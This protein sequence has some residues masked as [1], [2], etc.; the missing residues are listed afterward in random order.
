MKTLHLYLTRQVLLALL[1]TVVVFT[2][3]LLLANVLREVL[4]LLVNQQITLALA[5]RAI[6]LLIPFVLVFALPMGMLTAAL[7]VFG[8]FSADQELTA[9]R[10]GGVSLLSL[11]TPV[12]LLSAALSLVCGWINLQIAPLCRVAYKQLLFEIGTTPGGLLLP[13]KTFIKDFPGRIVYVGRVDGTNLEDIL[14]YNLEGERV[15]SYIRAAAGRLQFDRARQIIQVDLFDAWRIGLLEGRR[16]QVPFFAAES[17]LTYTN[18]APT[19]TTERV[20]VTD[21]TFGQLRRE[22][23]TL[24]RRI[25]A[26]PAAASASR[27]Q[28]ARWLRELQRQRSDLTLPVRVQ[29]HRQVAFSFACV[30]FTLVGIPLGIRA[31]RRETTFGIALALLLVALYYSFIILGQALDTRPEYVPHLIVWAPNFLFQ[32]IGAVLLWRANRG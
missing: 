31:H 5:G 28:L 9:A 20:K 18:P 15:E 11:V 10:A 3:V 17:Q 21:M 8:R 30:G 13:A 2:F 14:I 19:R 27:E 12:L 6:V 1:L 26:P 4:N 22:L 23:R 29:I 16:T 32:A 7:L 24:E 25:F